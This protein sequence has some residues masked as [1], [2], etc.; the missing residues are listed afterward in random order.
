MIYNAVTRPR[1]ADQTVWSKRTTEEPELISNV[2]RVRKLYTISGQA[3]Q[4]ENQMH[5]ERMH[6]G[7]FTS[8]HGTR[9]VVIFPYVLVRNY[10]RVEFFCCAGTVYRA[11]GSGVPTADLVSKYRKSDMVGSV[12]HAPKDLVRGVQKAKAQVKIPVSSDADPK[13]KTSERGAVKGNS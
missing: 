8:S 3:F 1:S 9:E 4:H 12:L 11:P 13:A 2:Q 6:V 10:K 7:T 5:C